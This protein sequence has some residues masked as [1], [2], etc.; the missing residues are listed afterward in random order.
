MCFKYERVV[1]ADHTVQF[2]PQRIQLLPGKERRSYARATVEVRE[3]F[4]GSLSIHYA[5]ER[6][7]STEA[8]LEAPQLRAR[9]RRLRLPASGS[10]QADQPASAGASGGK[11][12]GAST[13]RADHPW[14]KRTLPPS[15]RTDQAQ[16]AGSS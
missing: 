12:T 11:Q 2:G 9:G 14:R 6:L 4:D 13:P 7:A 1:A 15:T 16:Q 10:A 8:P 3:H 5:G